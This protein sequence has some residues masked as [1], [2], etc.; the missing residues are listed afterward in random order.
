[1][2]LCYKP[3]ILGSIWAQYLHCHQKRATFPHI[4]GE[5]QD[6]KVL[7]VLDL[8]QVHLSQNNTVKLNNLRH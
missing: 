7:R 2:C 8:T 6:G 5:L 3:G 1:M 4:K